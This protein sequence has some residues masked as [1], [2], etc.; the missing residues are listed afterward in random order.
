MGKESATGRVWSGQT[1][2]PQSR[3]GSGR[4]GSRFRRVGSGSRIV[5]R[6]QTTLQCGEFVADFLINT[7]CIPSGPYD[8]MQSPQEDQVSRLSHDNLLSYCLETYY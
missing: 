5:T 3:V 8:F 6:G 1:F 2:C 7:C 4:V